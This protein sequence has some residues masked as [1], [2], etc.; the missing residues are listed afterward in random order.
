MKLPPPLVCVVAATARIGFSN[1]GDMPVTMRSSPR[2]SRPD[3]PGRTSHAFGLPLRSKSALEPQFGIGEL[4]SPPPP[5]RDGVTEAHY[6]RWVVEESNKDAGDELR[7][8]NVSQKNFRKSQMERFMGEQQRKVED[9]HAQMAKAKDEVETVHRRN[10]EIGQEMRLSLLELKQSVAYEK[11]VWSAKG[12]ELVENAKNVQSARVLERQLSQR[13]RRQSMGLEAKKER[14]VLTERREADVA[15]EEARKKDIAERVKQET[16]D[17]VVSASRSI[18]KNEK[19]AIGD[20]VRLQEA[21]AAEARTSRR[22]TFLQ[23]AKEKG[24]LA[25]QE[26]AQQ[27]QDN[28]RLFEAIKTGKRHDAD[29][30]KSA[31]GGLVSQR[32]MQADQVR[33]TR[34]ADKERKKQLLEDMKRRNR[35]IH[36]MLYSS[37]FAPRDRAAKVVLPG[38][39]VGGKAFNAYDADAVAAADAAAA[40]VAS[41]DPNSPSPGGIAA[42]GRR[43]S[44]SSSRGHEDASAREE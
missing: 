15:V 5:L 43:F 10:L 6:S 9:S 11:Q 23:R 8:F 19:S 35:E 40:A 20:A 1:F 3:S 7:Q 24:E 34:V 41:G 16:S 44:M 36:D 29:T 33:S 31:R 21:K 26:F 22:E 4:P 28:R 25:R 42:G 39:L 14:E 12:R 37:K 30:I 18:I 32:K 17:A 13:G 2:S 38:R 27:Q